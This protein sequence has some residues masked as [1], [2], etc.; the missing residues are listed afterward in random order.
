MD[1]CDANFTA[2]PTH[3][4]VEPL[5][6]GDVRSVRREARVRVEIRTG[7]EGRYRLLLGVDHD[8]RGDD[9]CGLWL[10][11]IFEDC[12]KEVRLLGMNG[13]LR[14]TVVLVLCGRKPVSSPERTSNAAWGKESHIPGV[15]AT[16]SSPPF[17]LYTR[18][19]L[20]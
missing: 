16:G 4:G 15:I 11:V 9:V 14:E 10:G 18:P 17:C 8:E 6:P 1:F 20:K 2:L 12:N 13:K 5:L 3:I 7:D 19:S